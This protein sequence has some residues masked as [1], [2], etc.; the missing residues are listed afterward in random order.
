ML[1]ELFEEVGQ[2][3][4]NNISQS[5]MDDRAESIPQPGTRSQQYVWTFELGDAHQSDQ[6]QVWLRIN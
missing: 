5:L 3:T 4:Y 1:I 6:N 2:P